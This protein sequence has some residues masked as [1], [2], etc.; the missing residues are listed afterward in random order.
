VHLIAN[1]FFRKLNAH[2]AKNVTRTEIHGTES[3]APDYSSIE[4]EISIEKLKGHN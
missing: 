2:C 4:F 1:Y 3:L